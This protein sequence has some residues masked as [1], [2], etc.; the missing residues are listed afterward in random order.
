MSK[1]LEQKAVELSEQL[2][3]VIEQLNELDP[4]QYYLHQHNPHQ[5]HNCRPVVQMTKTICS[6]LLNAC[7]A[8]GYG[9]CRLCCN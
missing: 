5:Y 4:P 8:D 2:K 9:G 6:Q 3:Q 1:E 7:K